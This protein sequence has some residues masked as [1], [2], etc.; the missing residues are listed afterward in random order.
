MSA[1][2]FSFA[3]AVDPAVAEREV[4]KLARAETAY[5]DNVYLDCGPET[6]DVL[7]VGAFVMSPNFPAFVAIDRF[8][9]ARA[10]LEGHALLHVRHAGLPTWRAKWDAIRKTPNLAQ[11][12]FAPL[13]RG[14]NSDDTI[15][16]AVAAIERALEDAEERGRDLILACTRA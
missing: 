3:L 7:G 1:D 15:S 16:E 4:T 12:A 9:C 11:I 5:N 8:G 13:D 14:Y 2:F 10:L 6:L